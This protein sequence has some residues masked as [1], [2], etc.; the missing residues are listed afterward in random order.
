[1]SPTMKD[2]STNSWMWWEEVMR[3]AMEAYQEWL[4]A[5]PVQKLYVRPRALAERH[6]GW[7]RLEQRGQLM[8]LNAVPSGVKSEILASR[9]TSSTEVMFALFRR[10]QPGGLVERSRL[11]RSLVEP[12]TPGN[13][14][15]LL[16]ILRGWRRSLRRA[17]ELDITTP[18]ATLLLGA[19]DRMSAPVVKASSQAAFRVSSTR[20]TLGVDVTPTLASVLGFADSLL[21]EA[22]TLA[23]GDPM[24]VEEVKPP[25]VKVKAMATTLEEKIDK[26]SAYRVKN[27]TAEKVCR[28]W[29]S[30]EGC[31]RGK[32]CKFKH[33]WAGIEK[34]GR[35]FGCSAQG[36]AKKDCPVMKPKGSTPEKP[37]VKVVKEKNAQPTKAENAE[38]LAKT[39]G[40]EVS[41]SA[42]P[43]EGDRGAGTAGD[44][45]DLLNEAT[46]LLKSLRPATSIKAIRLSSL[47]VREGGRPLLD[48]GATHCLRRAVSEEEWQRGQEVNVELAAG[49][50]V[51]R[52][53]PWTKTLLTKEDVQVIVPLGVLISLGYEAVWEKTRFELTDPAGITL[54]TRIE[55]SC[56]TIS[57]DLAIELIQEIERSMVRERARLAFLAGE[58]AGL[59]VNDQ[60]AAF[61]LKYHI[62]CWSGCCRRRGGQEKGFRGIATS[63]EGFERQRRS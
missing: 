6:G 14:T 30:E 23:L 28:F 5:E 17:Q 9:T 62:T 43:N 61:S 51:L 22:E 42:A 48:G 12:K 34:K 52:L 36:H 10:Y 60:E 57:E 54:D 33:D 18:D 8:L 49:S 59:E 3:S 38:P 56:P 7:A 39:G 50:A 24:P 11:L 26:S 45:K 55:N 40:S 41:D 20:A 2:L 46:T 63:E 15:E 27:E 31:R 47:E 13:V 58:E 1:M 44:V 21:A 37:V 32:D 16:E 19:V 4:R 35:C 29:G 25:T 53:L